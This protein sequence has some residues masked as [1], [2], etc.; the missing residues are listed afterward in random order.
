MCIVSESG[1]RALRRNVTWDKGDHS[2]AFL[3]PFL[4]RSSV[5]TLFKP[6][7]MGAP[8]VFVRSPKNVPQSNDSTRL[9]LVVRVTPQFE[10]QFQEPSLVREVTEAR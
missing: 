9:Y 2:H 10:L 7:T 4:E 6:A 8:R 3:S 1:L 5:P